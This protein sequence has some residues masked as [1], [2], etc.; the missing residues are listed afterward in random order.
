[1]YPY[2]SAQ[3]LFH[4]RAL[5]LHPIFETFESIL[6]LVIVLTKAISPLQYFSSFKNCFA[7]FKILVS[8]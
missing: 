1:M 2:H 7:A 4:R 3:I 6:H 5:A 8:E